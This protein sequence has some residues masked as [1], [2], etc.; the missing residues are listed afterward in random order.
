MLG[1]GPPVTLVTV[2]MV[3]SPTLLPTVAVF[4]LSVLW[5][6]QGNL[7]MPPTRPGQLECL[8]VTNML[9]CESTVLLQETLGM[10]PVKVNMTGEVVT[11][12]I[13]LR[14]NIPLWDK[15][16][17]MLVFPTVLL[18]ARTLAWLAVKQCPRLPKLACLPETIFPSLITMTPP[19]RVLSEIQSPAY[20]M[21][22]VLVLPIMTS[23]LLTPP[24][25]IL[26]V[27]ISLVSETTVAL[28]RL[29]RTIG[30]LSLLPS[31]CLTLKYLGVPTLL[32]PTLL[33]AGVTVPMV[34][35]NPLGLPLL[36]LTLNIL[37][38][39]H[40]PKSSFPFLTM[41]PLVNVL[42]LFRLRMVALPETMVI[43]PFPVAQW[44]VL[45][46]PPLTLR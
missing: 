24:L 30:T 43:K 15:L 5:K 17:N 11:S 25:V 39:E 26:K 4:A 13:T 44:H 21:V 27:P 10:G 35:T 3:V 9:G 38:F 46:G 34:R 42:T 19:N 45:R 1:I 18:R 41:G 20:D 12:C 32:R 16:R 31:S 2:R 6:T 40:T 7:T 23:I 28:R 36:T 22:D 14:A 29:L 8:A 33:N 37:T